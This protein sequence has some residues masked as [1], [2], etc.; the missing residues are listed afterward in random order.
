MATFL[1]WNLNKRPLLNQVATL[2]H[3]HKIDVLILAESG[4]STVELLEALNGGQRSQFKVPSFVPPS[5]RL[6]FFIRYPQRSFKPVYDDGHVSIRRL[7]PPIGFEILVVAVHLPSK[8]HYKETDQTLNSP[9]V[10]QAIERAETTVGHTRTVVVGDFN[11]NPFETG[12][13]GAT[14][15][16]AV[17]DRQTALRGERTV[18]GKQYRFF[19]NP[20]WGRMGDTSQGP[21]G[22]YYFNTSAYVNF[23]WNTFDQVL[24]RPELLEFFPD[25]R[26]VV[27]SKVDEQS[28]LSSRGIPDTALGSDHLPL[29]FAVEI[30]KGI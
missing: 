6:S 4:L 23:F 7:I 22:T 25:E 9:L 21:P 14:G 5:S 28:L 3:E 16:H 13:V 15:F 17:L 24:V 12:I 11:M 27:L 20:M 8:L 26:V 30:E 18:Q 10:S 19:Y 2:C 1:F 29:L